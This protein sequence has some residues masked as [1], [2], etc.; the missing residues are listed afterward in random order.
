M[1]TL[2]YGIALQDWA[3][4]VVTDLRPYGYIGALHSPEQWQDWATQV[5]I[6]PQLKGAVPN[7]WEFQQWQDWAERLCGSVN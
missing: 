6:L 2:P 7:P 4:Q 1:I 3:D 5:T